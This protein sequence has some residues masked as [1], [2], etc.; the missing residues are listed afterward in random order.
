MLQQGSDLSKVSMTRLWEERVS[1]LSRLAV[2]LKKKP[3]QELKAGTWR[4]ELTWK[5]SAVHCTLT[6]CSVFL[7]V[8]PRTTSPGGLC[9]S[10]S[11]INQKHAHRRLQAF[12]PAEVFSQ[13][14][15][16]LPR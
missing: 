5:P 13:L 2:H 1:L 8:Q 7:L 16:L 6:A 3:G 10:R 15:F 14:R 4:E 11:I 9:P 12:L